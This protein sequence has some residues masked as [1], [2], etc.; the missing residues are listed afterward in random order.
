[1]KSFDLAKWKNLFAYPDEWF[2]RGFIDASFVEAQAADY[3]SGDERDV[4][5]FKW[6]V[7][8]RALHTT[9]FADRA[10]FRGFVACMEADPNEHLYK[11]AVREILDRKL[12]P[13]EWFLEYSGS[14]LMAQAKLAEQ[15]FA[16]VGQR[17]DAG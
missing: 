9:D 11:G 7:Y 14:R 10:A 3:E 5:H 15:I 4:E 12:V 1:M 17:E 6:A 2:D 16:R 13:V 8:R